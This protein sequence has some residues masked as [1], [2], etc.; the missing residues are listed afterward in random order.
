MLKITD[1]GAALG[2]VVL[3]TALGAA[4]AIITVGGMLVVL[5]TAPLPLPAPDPMPIRAGLLSDPALLKTKFEVPLAVPAGP[6]TSR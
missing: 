5:E 4:V 1:G 2:A 3:V 6:A